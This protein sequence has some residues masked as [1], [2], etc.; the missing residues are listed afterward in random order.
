MKKK[1]NKVLLIAALVV[2]VLNL[3]IIGTALALAAHNSE[4]TDTNISTVITLGEEAQDVLVFHCGTKRDANGELLT[5]GGRVICTT[6]MAATLPEAILKSYNRAASIDWEGKY[7]RHDI[8]QD[9]LKL[10]V[11]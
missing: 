7:L 6:A 4:Q 2:V 11:Q 3:A 1:T 10:M 9:L 5:N 8:G